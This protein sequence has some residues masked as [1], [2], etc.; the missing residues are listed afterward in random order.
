MEFYALSQEGVPTTLN[1][2]RD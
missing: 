1:A 2:I